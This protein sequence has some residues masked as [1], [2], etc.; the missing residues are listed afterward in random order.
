M[1][2]ASIIKFIGN[3]DGVIDKGTHIVGDFSD[4]TLCGITLDG[5]EKTAGGYVSAKKLNCKECKR[6]ILFCKSIK[7]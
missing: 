2:E 1:R 5:D 3:G 4:Y 7:L 6:I